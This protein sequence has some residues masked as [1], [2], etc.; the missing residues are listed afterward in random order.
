MSVFEVSLLLLG[1]A[2]GG[3][4]ILGGSIQLKYKKINS[5]ASLLMIIGGVLTLISVFLN[6]RLA[7]Y[8]IYFLTIGL[9]LIHIA[10][11][12]NGF[13]M[14][15]KINLKHHIV[16][17]GISIALIVFFIIEYH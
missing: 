11:I 5:W 13:K 9:I 1:I 14:Y 10:T 8:G 2:Y 16:R 4:T 7:T 17:L 12:N 6:S 3:L 15:G